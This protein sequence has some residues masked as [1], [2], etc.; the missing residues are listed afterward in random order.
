MQRIDKMSLWERIYVPEILRG[1]SVTGY[2]FGVIL[3]STSSIALVWQNLF[4][5][6]SRSNIRRK[7]QDIPTPFAGD[8]A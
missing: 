3:A 2:R 4:K 1:L 6:P 5:R 7:E 8:I